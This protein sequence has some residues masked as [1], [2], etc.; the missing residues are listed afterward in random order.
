MQLDNSTVENP[1]PNVADMW[2]DVIIA[3]LPFVIGFL[4]IPLAILLPNL[5]EFDY[6]LSVVWP[7]L[8]FCVLS[9]FLISTV[10]LIL[11][12][13]RR[14]GLYSGLFFVGVFLLLSD[15][16]APL[17]WGLLDGESALEESR[18]SSLIEL[19]LIALLLLCW[20]KLPARKSSY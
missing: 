19:V 2:N 4:S 16:L 18:R 1:K 11:N 12:S 6:R 8:G 9:I 7:F 5:I 3:S 17:Q 14:S 20:V 13:H 15:I 10:G